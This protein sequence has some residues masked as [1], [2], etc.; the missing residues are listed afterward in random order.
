MK[1]TAEIPI[2]K[3]DDKET[4]HANEET[5][6]L[7]RPWNWARDFVDVHVGGHVYQVSIR[8]LQDAI[9]TCQGGRF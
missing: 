3:F 6:T 8:D 2:R 5:S 4:N 7:K 9:R 1:V